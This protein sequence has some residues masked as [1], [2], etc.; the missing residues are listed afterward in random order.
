[1]LVNVSVVIEL[2]V[3]DDVPCD[4]VVSDPTMLSSFTDRYNART[5]QSLSPG[6]V[7]HDLLNLRRRGE[8]KGGLPRLRR[9]FDGRGGGNASDN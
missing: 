3:A 7:G 4:R 5:G 2:Y 8:A 9:A 6:E 1:M